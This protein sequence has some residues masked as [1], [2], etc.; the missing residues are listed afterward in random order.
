MI[1]NK[2]KKMKA[3]KATEFR[4]RNGEIYVR[5]KEYYFS[6][7]EI[8]KSSTL[9]DKYEPDEEELPVNTYKSKK[10][11]FKVILEITTITIIDF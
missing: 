6:C 2:T 11:G 8:L 5:G 3:I 10:S 4:Q 9:F 1:N 7:M